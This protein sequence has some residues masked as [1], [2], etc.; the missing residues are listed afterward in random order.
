MSSNDLITMFFLVAAVLIFFQ[1]RSVLGRRTGNEKP[2]LDPYTAREAAKDVA[3]GD[4]KVVT[5][6]RRDDADEETL[7]AEIDAYAPQGTQLNDGLRL[8]INTDPSFRPKE[9]LNGAKIAY[10]MI[11]MAFAQ[12]DR[13]TLKNLLSKEVYEGFDAALAERDRL[14]EV[15]KSTFVGINKADIIQAHVTNHEEQITL[16]INSQIISATFDK[17][18]T[19]IDGSEETVGDVRDVWTFS[20]DTRSKDPNWKL[21]A[22][23]SVE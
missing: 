15:V 12:S 6:A 23:E 20:R 10:E 2:P 9:F 18:G 16:R 19:L 13:K 22:T 14:G 11:V 5:L 21:V 7:Y 8:I 3:D 17:H 4:N 1:L